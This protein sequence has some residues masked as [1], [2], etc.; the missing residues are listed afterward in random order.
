MSQV[1]VEKVSVVDA[2]GAASPAFDTRHSSPSLLVTVTVT[3][4]V[5]SLSSA[6]LNAA[7]P[8]AS[9]TVSR[10]VATSLSVRPASSS[11]ALL[12][13]RDT[14]CNALY[15]VSVLLGSTVI[16]YDWLSS[17]TSS[18]CPVT[19]TV[20]AA[21]QATTGGSA[22]ASAAA[23]NVILDGLTCASPGSLLTTVT[24]TDAVGALVSRTVNVSAV[25]SSPV[26]SVPAGTV[27][28]AV[29]SSLIVPVPVVL[30]SSSVALLGSLKVTFTVSS[31]SS[32]ASPFTFTVT[33][34]LLDPAAIVAVPDASAV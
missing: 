28:P 30:S 8:P 32:V 9:V 3:D 18:S 13:D 20:C 2:A 6:T 11:S 19:V 16:E 14:V 4:A 31:D 27:S 10:G 12:P 33:V 26:T 21:F 7:V 24:V 1:V 15:F 29:S 5:G 22:S 25:P 23:P 17:S 34:V